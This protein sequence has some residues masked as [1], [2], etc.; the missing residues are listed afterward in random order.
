MALIDS[1]GVERWSLASSWWRYQWRLIWI[2][3]HVEGAEECRCA[4][5][6]AHE[7]DEIDQS[8]KAELPSGPSEGRRHHLPRAE[9]L[10]AELDDDRVGLVQAVR[11]P[12]VL[13]DFDDILGNALAE[14]LRL[15][16]CPFKLIVEFTGSGEDGQFTNASSESCLVSQIAVERPGVSREFGTVEQ[17]T[18]RA[19]RPLIVPPL[20]SA[21]LS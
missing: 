13:D 21:R 18:A 4:G 7:G 12:A 15:V 19:P 8:T 2:E 16:C 5:I 11:I 10:T 1:L 14:R 6:I 9:D 17:D 3:L 20:G